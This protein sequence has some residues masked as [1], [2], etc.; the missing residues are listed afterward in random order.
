YYDERTGKVTP[1]EE[2]KKEGC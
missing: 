2:C 1:G